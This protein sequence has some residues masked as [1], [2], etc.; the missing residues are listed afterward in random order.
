M[1]FFLI[2]SCKNSNKGD[3]RIKDYEAKIQNFKGFFEKAPFESISS[4]Y[5]N[6]YMTRIIYPSGIDSNGYC[7]VIYTYESKKADFDSVVSQIKSKSVFNSELT[8]QRNFYVP[9][10]KESNE[11]DKYPIP[12]LDDSFQ[13]LLDKINPKK[14][15]V[16]IFKSING[17]FFNS[18]GVQKIIKWGK[19]RSETFKGKGF[20]NGAI[21]DYS[22]NYIIYWTIIW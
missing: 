22:N 19:P 15:E 6:K 16:Y 11:K 7:G 10:Y 5:N 17:N 18:K 9:S 3:S 8:K 12:K 14:S 20:S 1:T 21:I 13:N 2:V 4:K